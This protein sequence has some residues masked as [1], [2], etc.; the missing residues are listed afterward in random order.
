MKKTVINEKLYR[1]AKGEL[2]FIFKDKNGNVIN[3]IREE[4][5]V[6]IFAKE[7][8]SHTIPYS[9]TWDPDAGTA[10]AWVD[11]IIDPNEVFAI[12]YILFGASFDEDGVPLDTNDPRYYTQD[13]VTQLAVPIRLEPGAWYNGGLINAVPIAEP[14]RPLKRVENVAFEPTYQPA[15]TPLLQED[16]R[17]INNIVMFET[18]LKLDEYNGFGASDSDYFTITEVALAAGKA[19]DLVGACE[20]TPREL[21]LEGASGTEGDAPIPAT[22]NG[23]DVITIDSASDAELIREGDQIMIVS[24]TAGSD[25]TYDTLGQV[26]PFYLVLD[27][28]TTGRELTL[29]REPADSDQ[30]VITGDIGIY[31]DTLRIFSHRI[32]QSPVKKSSD[33]EILCRWR[34]ILS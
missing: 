26:T 24:A 8:I 28:S 11:N 2:E 34:I 21:F 15:G 7:I 19:L 32:L 20:E 27:K 33:F 16:V 3:V 12:K 4:N 29:D 25:G 6:K 14:D 30:T 17:A 5:I 18:T 31:R 9:K 13:S 23:G 1:Y 10:G 22:A